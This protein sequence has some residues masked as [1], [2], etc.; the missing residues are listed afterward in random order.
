MSTL[1]I[2]KGKTFSNVSIHLDGTSFLSCVFDSCDVYYSGGP[3]DAVDCKWR[4]NRF[5]FRDA[6][7]RTGA[8][9]ADMGWLRDG[10][11]FE[12]SYDNDPK[13]N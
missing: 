8:F 10:V 7:W 2:E 4:N 13:S 5:Y 11:P 6:A 3:F 12:I 1:K 9:F